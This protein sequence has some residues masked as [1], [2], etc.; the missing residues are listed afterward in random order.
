MSRTHVGFV[1][2]MRGP[3]IRKFEAS[4]GMPSAADGRVDVK[5]FGAHIQKL[6][7]FP[8]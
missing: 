3:L 6:D 1:G 4:L 5:S 7:H 8:K 2:G